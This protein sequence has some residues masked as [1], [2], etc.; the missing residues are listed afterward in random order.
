MDHITLRIACVF[1]DAYAPHFA[2]LAASLA[3]TRGAE[4][5][6]ITLLADQGLS[7][8]VIKQIEQF[9]ASLDIS[10]NLVDVD[11]TTRQR[12]PPAGKYPALIW[13]R[14]LLPELLPE[15]SRILYLDTDTLALQSLWPLFQQDLGSKLFGAVAQPTREWEKQCRLLGIDP[16]QDYLNSGVLLMDL[17]TMRRDGF[18]ARALEVAW[19]QNTMFVL[20]DQEVLNL[21]AQGRWKKLPPKWNA[22]SHLWLT[23]GRDDTIYPE[24]D[25]LMA[26]CSPAIVHFEGTPAVKPWHYRSIHPMRGLYR[27]FRSQ[28][29]W[30]LDQLEGSS[31][32]AAALRRL[33]LGWQ[34]KIAGAK[35][36]LYKLAGL[37]RKQ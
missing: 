18:T 37:Q 27:H 25:Y 12:L 30:P 17:E 11:D 28:T 2:A 34:Y 3:A 6:E 5:I 22:M 33:P 26:R 24:S 23:P 32:L 1:D 19:A 15:C 21:A 35:T 13:Y 4:S 36:L 9:L 8:G 29:P 31:P 10:L 14:L 7:C 16:A 20:P